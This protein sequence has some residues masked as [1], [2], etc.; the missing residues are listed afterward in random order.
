MIWFT[1]QLTRLENVPKS[2]SFTLNNVERRLEQR[3]LAWS[4]KLLHPLT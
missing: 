3:S 2:S 1:S 4:L